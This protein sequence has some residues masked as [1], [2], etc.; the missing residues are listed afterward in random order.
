[1]RDEYVAEAENEPRPEPLIEF[2]RNEVGGARG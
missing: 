2:A 1:M